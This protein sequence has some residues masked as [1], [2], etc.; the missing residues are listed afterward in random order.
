MSVSSPFNIMAT[1]TGTGSSGAITFSS[2]PQTYKSLVI[3]GQVASTIGSGNDGFYVKVNA[4]A[5]TSHYSGKSCYNYN[6][7]NYYQD[8]YNSYA[9]W[10]VTG[11]PSAT[12]Y[13]D[14][15]GWI[16]LTFPN[17][18]Q[19]SGWQLMQ[20]ET[21]VQNTNN[22]EAIFTQANGAYTNS[23]P[24]ALTELTLTLFTANWTTNSNITMYGLG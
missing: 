12:A 2:I 11:V 24:A 9:G 19:S 15:L 5:T 23:T 3:I 13:A 18:T 22:T 20:A 1:A 10:Y 6:G 7:T 8:Y 16:E 21:G 14:K 4:D 17:Y